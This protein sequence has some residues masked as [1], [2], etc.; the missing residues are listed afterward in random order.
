M[1][2]CQLSENC[3]GCVLRNL[4][5]EQY[6]AYK[7][8]TARKILSHIEQKEII[9]GESIYIPEG[10]RRRA[11]MAFNYSKKHLKM[12]F[13]VS[14]S[15][16]IIDC[17]ECALLTDKLNNNLKNIRIL[18]EGLCVE[19]FSVKKGKKFISQ[20]INEGEVACCEADNGI[21]I[22]ISVPFEPELNHRMIICEQ[23]NQCPDIIRVS[24]QKS[25]TTNVE[26]IIEKSRPLIKN[27]GVDVYIPAG[28]FLQASQA[29][30]QA[31]INCVLN[32]IG[33]RKGKIAD[34]FCGVG[35]FTYPLAQI[36]GN[37]ILAVDLSAALLEGFRHS[38]NKN[39]LMNIQ[40]E[41]K[42]LFKYPLD[43]EEL[44]KL[45]IV[46]FDPPRAGAAAQTAQLAKSKVPIVVAVS[47]NP[48][49]FVNDANTLIS[50]GYVLKEV[51]MIDQFVYSKHTEL[52]ALFEK[53]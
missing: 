53:E 47:C 13:N 9:F 18:I 37:Q 11:S 43:T 39:Q 38:V 15:H 7:E 25:K 40:I 49:T 42:N 1:R 45:D 20:Y 8:S 36:K 3:G 44:S 16:E 22:L 33:D 50:G 17:S 6:K 10:T 31:L 34:L 23:I 2:I 52:V 51:T 46:V 27:S 21:D 5:D 29:G 32:Y 24:W 19:S 41:A 26:T 48:Y 12:G 28:T 14:Q 30:E 4:N 35:T